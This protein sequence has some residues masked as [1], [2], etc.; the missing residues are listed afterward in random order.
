MHAMKLRIKGVSDFDRLKIIFS[1]PPL[2]VTSASSTRSN[3][4][5]FLDRGYGK[6]DV[7]K[8]I[9]QNGY[10]VYVFAATVGSKHP[11]IHLSI[12]EEKIEKLLQKK[13]EA[14]KKYQFFTALNKQRIMDKLK[15]W[16]VDDTEKI[17]GSEV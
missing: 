5:F 9:D 6:L 8:C 12:V 4:E 14:D 13:V 1:Q 10:H 16:I 7:F 15:S 17:L 11:W 2:N 3:V